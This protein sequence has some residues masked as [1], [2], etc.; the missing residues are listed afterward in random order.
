M[1]AFTGPYCAGVGTSRTTSN[2]SRSTSTMAAKASSPVFGKTPGC[3]VV[4]V[5]WPKTAM[6]PATAVQRTS[7]TYAALVREG[8]DKRTGFVR[9]LEASERNPRVVG[10]ISATSGC[11]A[12]NRTI[13]QTEVLSNSSTAPGNTSKDDSGGLTRE[14]RAHKPNRQ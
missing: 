13:F 1:Q 14:L 12:C 7:A 10:R 8:A 9:C 3:C 2:V 11:G 5:V 4:P 6:L